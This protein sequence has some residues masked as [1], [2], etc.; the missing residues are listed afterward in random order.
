MY[1]GTNTEPIPRD[2]LFGHIRTAHAQ[3]TLCMRLISSEH[4]QFTKTM[5]VTY[6]NQRSAH[7]PLTLRLCGIYIV[8]RIFYPYKSIRFPLETENIQK[9]K[10]WR[11][12]F[13]KVSSYT[14]V[15]LQGCTIRPVAPA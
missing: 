7:A 3:T 13:I 9:H 14:A 15:L 11:L 10:K 4:A 12:G 6:F 1:N 8:C 5:F 2:H